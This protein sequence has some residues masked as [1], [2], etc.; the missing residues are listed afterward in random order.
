[1]ESRS[2]ALVAAVA[3]VAHLVATRRGMAFSADSWAY[4]E[5]SVSVLEG[6]G[7]RYVHGPAITEWP[8]LTAYYLAGAQGALGVSVQTVALA[9][10]LLFALCAW[11]TWRLAV[12]VEDGT[13][14]IWMATSVAAALLLLLPWYGVALS[15]PVTI[16]LIPWL[17]RDL[18]MVTRTRVIGNAAAARITLLLTLLM[19]A[20]H[21]ALAVVAASAAALW[22]SVER[23]PSAFAR[24]L[25]LSITPV[26][27]WWSVNQLINVGTTNRVQGEFTPA[28]A[29]LLAQQFVEALGTMFITSRAG[30]HLIT[31]AALAGAIAAGV[32]TAFRSAA[33]HS[34]LR[35][36]VV[37]S[38]VAAAVSLALHALAGPFDPFFVRAVLA[39]AIPLLFAVALIADYG[40]SASARR[41]AA[42]LLV[43]LAIVQAERAGR[44]LMAGAAGSWGTVLPPSA[45]IGKGAEQQGR[46]VALPAFPWFERTAPRGGC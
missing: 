21:A 5:G 9:W 19:L 31:L 8:P 24:V 27:I 36:L 15:E 6:C 41:F 28:R 12:A 4:W 2:T 39:S 37:F 42:A 25:A 7:Y 23:R 17:L 35:V 40:S 13:A 22:F 32:R 10:T 16:A 44:V 14:R 45:A 3:A 29:L 38:I 11:G 33:A 46:D 18:V 34:S 43:V 30:L 20:R 1:M 26:I